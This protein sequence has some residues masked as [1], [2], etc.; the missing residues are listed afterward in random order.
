[1]KGP[2]SWLGI[3][4]VGATW[5]FE[6]G[7]YVGKHRQP[8]AGW[9]WGC[10]FGW[11]NCVRVNSRLLSCCRSQMFRFLL[12]PEIPCCCRTLEGWTGVK[13]PVSLCSGVSSCRM[14]RS[15]GL[16]RH[17]ACVLT[18]VQPRC[19]VTTPKLGRFAIRSNLLRPLRQTGNNLQKSLPVYPKWDAE[20]RDFRTLHN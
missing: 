2:E 9:L 11:V 7:D 8:S 10:C 19:V 1:M 16:P 4:G 13:V 5:S 14:R 17:W 18:N 12:F 3:L 15:L 6:L 20:P